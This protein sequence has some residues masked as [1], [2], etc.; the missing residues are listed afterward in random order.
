MG[1]LM[2]AYGL[3]QK[4]KDLKII[5]LEKGHRLS[6]RQCPIVEK[7]AQ[8][9]VNCK[10]C[11][12]MNGLAGAGAFSDGKFI[13][14]TE[15][16]GHLQ[17][18]IGDELSQQYMSELDRILIKFGAPSKTFVPNDSLVELCERNGLLIKKGTVK[19]F[20]TEN[21]LRIMNAL[22]D[23]IRSQCTIVSECAVT[24]VFPDSHLVFT[25]LFSEPIYAEHIVFAVGRSGGKFFSDWCSQYSVQT[26]NRNVDLGV[27]VELKSE[28]W[29]NIST[30]AYDPKISYISE[31]YKD[32]TRMFC[33]NEGGHV[34]MEN[35]FGSKTVN[36]HAYQ[37]LEL[38]S[39]N[40]NFALLTS[41]KLTEPFNNPIEYVNLIANSVNYISGGTV[42]VQRFGD[43]KAGCRT[44]TDKLAN[45]SVKPTL[46]VAYPGDLSLSI[47]KRQL[48][49][50]IETIYRL[51]KIAP[52]TANDDTLLYG[53]EGKYYSSIPRIN[54]FEIEGCSKIYACGD[55]S[56]ITRSLAQAGANGLYISDKILND[57]S[58]SPIN[59]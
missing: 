8:R 19:H 47:P 38:K 5:I 37:G 23:S 36:G 10:I 30:I 34:V 40:S 25:D 59:G 14:S 6:E 43:L 3:L 46:A 22:I 53:V 42:I 28:T 12:I 48:D 20:G 15:Y 55:G 51:D 39:E 4:K 7:T 18:F 50:I 21:N 17:E 27:R 1:G 52:G 49:S 2:T 33:F 24:D 58:S 16:G 9:C 11:S 41:I 32:E 35:T 31:F 13:I 57:I 45:S 54:D 56:G 44:T 26:S 29:K